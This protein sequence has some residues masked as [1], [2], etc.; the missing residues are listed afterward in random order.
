M[1]YC[2][3][4]QHG[5]WMKSREPV[6][7][8]KCTLTNKLNLIS[9]RGNNLIPQLNILK[10][11]R[12]LTSTVCEFCYVL[13]VC[14]H[15]QD[16][17]K[18]NS[19]W[20]CQSSP[21]S[22]PRGKSN[23]FGATW[24]RVN[25]DRIGIFWGYYPFKIKKK[26]HDVPYLFVGSYSFVRFSNVALAVLEEVHRSPGRAP[27]QWKRDML[28]VWHDRALVI[29][30]LSKRVENKTIKPKK[31]QWNHSIRKHGNKT[32]YPPPCIPWWGLNMHKGN[33]AVGG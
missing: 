18:L 31:R 19:D 21:L 3:H 16:A 32:P 28:P 29:T 20:G 2:K 7:P 12:K 24:G 13:S 17:I 9:L 14:H 11:V 5:N 22:F 33:G 8:L 23:W 1:C 6:K 15:M 27:A 30:N 4:K 26:D 10:W 25:E